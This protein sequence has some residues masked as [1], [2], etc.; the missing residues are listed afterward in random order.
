VTQDPLAQIQRRQRGL[1]TRGQALRVLTENELE[2]RLRSARRDVVR[3]GVYRAAGAP[4]DW[5][6]LLLAACLAGGSGA[7]ASF[8]SAAWMWQLERF[9]QPDTLEITV[10]RERRARL[11]GV[12]VHDSVVSGRIHVLRHHGIPITTAART[13]CDLTACCHP[14]EVERA[15]DNALRRNLTTLS[16]VARVFRDLATRG[17][18][19]ST[20]MRALLDDRATGPDLGDSDAEARIARW[21][22]GAEL[23]K[24]VQQHRVRVGRRS[25]KLDLAYPRHRI[26]IEFDG[27][28]THGTRLAFDADRVR[29]LD[30]EDEGW[31]V[32]H[33][34]SRSTR[35]FVVDRVRRALEKATT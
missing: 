18:R 2:A 31:R 26:A 11:P 1:V 25:Y 34:T 20:V 13:L 19:H 17:R 35:D 22:V 7:V 4:E 23:P 3:T 16:L 15:L 8:R 24:P 6:Q 5:E 9:S 12:R 14:R 33:F 10:P 27:W 21:L 32:L 28:A 29:D 30:L